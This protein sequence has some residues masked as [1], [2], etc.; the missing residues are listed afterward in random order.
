MNLWLHITWPAWRDQP[1]RVVLA[2][3]AVMLGVA[4]AF[5]VHLLNG[6]ALTE[7]AR[8]A[9]GVN[10]QPDLVL[11]AGNGSLADRDLAELLN[12]PEVVTASPVLEAQAL[13]PGQKGQ[14]GGGLTVRLIGIDPFALIGA[15]TAG[16]PLAPELTPQFDGTGMQ[17]LAT[18]TVHLNA[19]AAARLP[20]GAATL[21]LR[22]PQPGHPAPRDIDLTVGGRIAAGNAPLGVLDIADAQA[23]FGRLGALDRIDVQLAP[24]TDAI[25]WARTLPPRWRATPPADEGERLSDLTRAYRI[26]L[27][28]LA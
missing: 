7:F 27:G 19:A 21:K 26:N 15:A 1:A 10:G 3:V 18:Y 14:F 24:G 13:W 12:R 17:A 28:L 5:G 16:R 22:V 23:L 11:R 6:A 9:R 4:L 8:A 20:S 2:I 25:T